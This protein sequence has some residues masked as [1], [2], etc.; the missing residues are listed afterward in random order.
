M[1]EAKELQRLHKMI[2]VGLTEKVT[3]AASFDSDE[4]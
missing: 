4:S 3:K 1:S 2:R